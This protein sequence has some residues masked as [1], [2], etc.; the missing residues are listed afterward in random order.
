VL[1]L[2]LIIFVLF[3]TPLLYSQDSEDEDT[4]QPDSLFSQE[5]VTDQQFEV[6]FNKGFLV[7]GTG[8]GLDS[9]KLSSAAS[10]TYYIG[11]SYNL[12][13]FKKDSL[14]KKTNFAHRFSFRF[15]PGISFFKLVYN[16]DTQPFPTIPDPSTSKIGLESQKQRL[17]YLELP[18]GMGFVIGRDDKQH[19]TSFVELGTSISFRID[20]THKLYFKRD[21]NEIITKF[22]NADNIN[23]WRFGLYAKYC[24]RWFGLF[25]YYRLNDLYKPNNYYLNHNQQL[26]PFPTIPPLE[27]G[28]CVQL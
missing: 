7:T 13:F 6:I 17:T 15:Q 10:G 16:S 9:F 14:N 23:R 2:L 11:L 27:V 20:A 24:Y 1:R 5:V 4:E 21:G 3:S 18:I 22:D 19:V 28:L 25:A 8:E 26:T 12:L